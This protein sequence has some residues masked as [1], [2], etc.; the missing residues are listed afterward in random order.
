MLKKEA[1]PEN[2]YLRYF[3]TRRRE[4]A[5]KEKQKKGGREQ[6]TG[7][8]LCFGSL[9]SRYWRRNFPVTHL[10]CFLFFASKPNRFIAFART[11]LRSAQAISLKLRVQT[12]QLHFCTCKPS[13]YAFAGRPFFDNP[14]KNPNPSCSEQTY[15]F[16]YSR[17]N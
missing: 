10:T 17:Q 11:S 5:K 15:G 13:R 16:W 2:E 9:G 3:C 4:A 1:H 8:F 6:G 7:A 12:A 14:L